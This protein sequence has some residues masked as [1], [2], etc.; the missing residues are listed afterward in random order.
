MTSYPL[1]VCGQM[2][3]MCIRDRS[4]TGVPGVHGQNALQGAAALHPQSADRSQAESRPAAETC[5]GKNQAKGAGT[6]KPEL[7]K[8]LVLNL[9][10]IHI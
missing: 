9:S 7:K 10:L 3:Q 1:F 5:E 6:M 8:L 2:V 4:G